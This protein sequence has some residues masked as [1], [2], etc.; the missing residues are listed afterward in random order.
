[1]ATVTHRRVWTSE[2]TLWV[3]A[4]ACALHATEEYFTGWQQWARETLGITMPTSIF[5]VMNAVLA[6]AALLL[7]C[8][9]WRR[10]TLSLII[11][12]ATL[13]N[14]MLLQGRVAPGLYT[15]VGLYLPFSTWALVGA[16]RDGVPRSAIA[17]AAVIGALVA[18]GVV[19]GARSLG[20]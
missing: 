11:P 18:V 7:A 5:V 8:T 9:G 2:W 20:G 16:A 4:A 3:V 19:V 15:A 13:V 14:A 1:M 6:A 17:A 10:P 12:V